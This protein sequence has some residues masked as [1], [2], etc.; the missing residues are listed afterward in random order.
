MLVEQYPYSWPRRVSPTSSDVR[1]EV[2]VEVPLRELLPVKVI[3]EG[4]NVPQPGVIHKS[5]EGDGAKVEKIGRRGEFLPSIYFPH[6]I[7]WEGGDDTD[8]GLEDW[9]QLEEFRFSL[10]LDSI[11]VS[12]HFVLMETITG[13]MTICYIFKQHTDSP[14]PTKSF[15]WYI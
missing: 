4:M 9:D 5:V 15:L 10:H 13:G 12:R 2:M 7:V 11:N 3:P 14:P 1:S 6:V 8:G